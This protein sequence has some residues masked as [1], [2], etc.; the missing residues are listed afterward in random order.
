MTGRSV[1]AE[2]KYLVADRAT[3]DRALAA[4]SFGPFAAGPA[5]PAA[6]VEDRYVDT[7]DGALAHA[8]YAGRIRRT[9]EATLVTLKSTRT[10]PGPLQRRVEL[11][12]AGPAPGDPSGGLDPAAW[13]ASAPR[14]AVLEIAAGMPL[15]EL[16]TIRQR[17]SRRELRADGA[18]VELSLDEVEVVVAGEVAD[19]FTELEA[20]LREGDE[21]RLVDL[22]SALEAWGTLQ[23]AG[24]SKLERAMASVARP[25][26][27]GPR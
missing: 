7:A 24:G 10:E 1:E 5:T 12:A 4:P 11:E 20:E 26:G 15:V 18:L 25:D 19:R 14:L 17:R 13:P 6:L 8:G 23:P 16:V 2:L 22:G 27:G 3:V 21:R 9:G